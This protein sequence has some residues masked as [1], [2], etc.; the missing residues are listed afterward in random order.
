LIDW[1]ELRIDYPEREL[2]WA[3]W[4]LSKNP[5]GDTLLHDRAHDFLDVYV[6]RSGR[7]VDRRTVIPLIR[8][9]L[10]MEICRTRTA[11]DPN[12]GDDDYTATQVRTFWELRGTSL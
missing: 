6:H 2:A 3:T 5:A 9:G 4:E 12:A 1:D 7:T 8:D 10:R 11:R